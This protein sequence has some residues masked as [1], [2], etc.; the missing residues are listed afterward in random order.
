MKLCGFDVRDGAR[1]QLVDAPVKPDRLRAGEQQNGTRKPSETLSIFAMRW[2][3]R[4]AA[5][6]IAAPIPIVAGRIC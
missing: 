2:D 4:K 5:H 1:E 6:G 3:R